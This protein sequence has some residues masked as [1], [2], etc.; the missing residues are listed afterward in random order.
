MSRRNSLLALFAL[1]ATAVAV[2]S[3]AC[4]SS[5]GGGGATPTPSVSGTPFTPARCQIVWM[6]RLP[7]TSKIDYYVVDAPSGAFVSGTNSYFIGDSTGATNVEG[8]FVYHYDL[9]NGSNAGAAVASSGVFAVATGPT[10]PLKI[11]G[12][13][14]FNDTTPQH[15]FTLSSAGLPVA[16][17]GSSG[18]GDFTGNW[19]DPGSPDT[20]PGIGTM[21]VLF[22]GSSFT[23]GGDLSYAECFE[24]AAF[25]A[26][27]HE[28]RISAAGRRA[29]DYLR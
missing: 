12:T 17:Q 24:A 28:Q 3:A 23:L 14:S 16:D 13:I 6:R 19:S 10:D 21:H 9:V 8:A 22:M 27:T 18:T 5:A 29:A 7:P 25:S 15:Y 2:G 26:M 11:G 20:T 1:T 4:S